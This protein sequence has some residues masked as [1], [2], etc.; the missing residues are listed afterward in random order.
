MV[1]MLSVTQ[2]V[3]VRLHAVIK[4]IMGGTGSMDDTGRALLEGLALKI[5]SALSSTFSCTDL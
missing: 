1:E 2:T 4:P 3:R 5:S